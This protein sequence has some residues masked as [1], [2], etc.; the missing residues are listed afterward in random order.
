[1]A[2]VNASLPIEVF[3]DQWV[4]VPVLPPGTS[5]T[6]A[7]VSGNPVQ[8]VA[9]GP[10][11][12]YGT[13][14]KG[15]FTME[16]A[17]S[18]DA[19]T[20]GAGYVLAVPVPQA[21]SIQLSATLPESGLEV[22]VIPASGVRVSSSGGE[23]NVSATVPSAN[24]VQIAWRAP[25]G[26]GPSI[27]RA[28]YRGE[29]GAVSVAWRA[30]LRVEL[31]EESAAMVPLLPRSLTLT[32]LSVDGKEAP[33]LVEEDRFATMV[34]GRGTHSIVASFQTPIL[35]ENGPPS[36]ELLVP[37][38]PVS[39]V[40][41]TL[42]G[43]KDVTAVPSASVSTRARGGA[44]EAVVHVPLTERVTLAWSEAIPETARRELRANASLY[45]VLHA[46]EGVLYGR[47]HVVYEVQ[48]GGTSRIEL[49]LPPVVEVNQVTSEDGAIAD[50]R[51]EGRVLRIFLDREVTSE[52]RL[53]VD[54][55]RSLG[56]GD[57]ETLPL[58][59]AR[60]VGRQRG[61]VA[62]V[63]T[64]DRALSPTD[65]GSATQVGE[66]QLPPFVRDTIERTVAHTFKYADAPPAMRAAAT[67]PERVAGRF[68]ADVDTL[69]SLGDVA[70]LSAASVEIH[71]KSGGLDRV[72]LTLPPGANLLNLVAPSLRTHRVV[73][74]AIEV[75]FTQE[76]EG[77]FR[78]EATYERL[79]AGSEAEAEASTIHVRGAEVEQGRIAVEA[80][81]AVEVSP[82]LVEAL[83]PLDVREL[84]RQLVLRT[85]HPILHAFRY[86][87]AEPAPRL[88]LRVTRHEIASVA[89]AVIDRAEHRTLFT[90]DGLAVTTSRFM[91]R[92]TRKQFVRVA[93]PEGSEVW[94]VFVAGKAEKPAIDGSAFLIKIVSSSEGFPVELVYAT[95]V[96]SIGALG[97]VSARL[98]RPDLLVTESRWD[99]YL[100]DGLDYRRPSTNMNVVLEEGRITGE[101]L[102]QEMKIADQTEAFRIHVPAAGVHFAFEMLYANHGE[103]EGR[104]R[105]PYASRA[106]VALGHMASLLG[107]WILYAALQLLVGKRARVGA[108]VLGGTL[109]LVPVVLYGVS[110]LPGLLLA[111]G[112]AV[113]RY[114]HEI[115]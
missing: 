109:V 101:A 95:K 19:S 16:L 17:Y 76:M 81:S 105:L 61:M 99:W 15:A 68:D 74:G 12:A 71:V 56:T 75:E 92:N 43:R 38:V 65:A 111:C 41:L 3:E 36:T 70:V 97:S 69:V 29:V 107:V 62:L 112:L 24:G 79:L 40:E 14:V 82:I 21:S 46:E 78:I 72:D 103:N 11:L 44:T 98:P 90:R 18:V 60:G 9:T 35:R 42:P 93:L 88:S 30:E 26:R 57:T 85:S 25:G 7:T 55:D 94:S 91:V 33:I 63:P 87:R 10:G 23:T 49:G 53:A 31:F 84:P 80:S 100:P 37:E 89:E 8:L 113:V 4:L 83:S 102:A 6:S 108:G 5:L 52:I 1:M 58:L 54:Y 45:H 48:H 2:E 51:V 114:R 66:N 28:T 73:D 13:K 106:G 104:V 32:S 115:W 22:T 110:P 39:R 20:T 27:G 50:W 96:P 64:R 67:A 59:E 34:R 86:V 77:D 47:A